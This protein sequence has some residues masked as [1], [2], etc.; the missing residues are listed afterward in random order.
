MNADDGIRFLKKFGE[1][2]TKLQ[3]SGFSLEHKNAQVFSDKIA[4]TVADTLIELK[5][6]QSEGLLKQL[7][8]THFKKLQRFMV[9]SD[10]LTGLEK[11]PFTFENLLHLGI[12][13]H[14]ND[15]WQYKLIAENPVKSVRLPLVHLAQAF[16]LL[17]TEGGPKVLEKLTVNWRPSDSKYLSP[18]LTVF[19]KLN[20][21]TVYTPENSNEFIK[22]TELVCKHWKACSYNLQNKNGSK[23][24][25]VTRTKRV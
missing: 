10:A 13:A 14:P 23:I 3:F 25:T 18:L 4:R 15:P 8:P 1:Q 16:N 2:I 17:N 22:I 21:L 11:I 9:Y 12:K 24:V 6:N 19:T 7:P 5:F 20:E